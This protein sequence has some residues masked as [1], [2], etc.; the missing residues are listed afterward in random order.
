MDSQRP[1]IRSN[2]SRPSLRKFLFFILLTYSVSTL[3][4]YGQNHPNL[5]FVCPSSALH[6]LHSFSYP[7]RID[8][9]FFNEVARYES[10]RK[11]L[12]C[13]WR[14]RR[15][16]HR[17]SQCPFRIERA[18]GKGGRIVDRRPFRSDHSV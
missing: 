12:L 11:P 14:R 18:G 17:R 2:R 16:L 10:C 6:N 8:R 5:E 9:V 7:L 15:D 3:Q 4:Q 13:R 1:R